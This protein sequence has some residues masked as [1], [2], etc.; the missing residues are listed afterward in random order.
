MAEAVK[1]GVEEAG[2][3]VDVFQY[4][5][6]FSTHA[7]VIF[8][9]ILSV[10]FRIPETLTEDVLAKMHAPP[11]TKY[12]TVS[13][14]DLLNY[15]AFLF[16]TPTR[17]GNMT[18]QWKTFID[19]TGQIWST[20]GYHGKYCGL[21]TSTGTQGGGQ[22]ATILQTVCNPGV[23]DYHITQYPYISEPYINPK[24]RPC[25]LV[26]SYLLTSNKG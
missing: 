18:A 5:T 10:S 4:V 20:G 12:P 13:P 9:N 8:C 25:C 26:D 24:S 2:G 17:Y 7:S 6:F 15:D 3:K 21:F 19:A 11:K 14:A 23:L 22:E 1:E 16:G